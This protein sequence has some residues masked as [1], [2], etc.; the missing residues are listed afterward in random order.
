MYLRN[1]V[2]DPGENG[3]RGR[4]EAFGGPFVFQWHL[5]DRCERSCRHCYREGPPRRD[6]GEAG[7]LSVL[8][9][10]RAFLAKRGLRGRLHL[11]G[12]E[13]ALCPGLDR[14]LAA[15]ARAGLPFRF[16]TGGVGL[17][18]SRAADLARSGCVGVQVSVEGT[19]A[20]HDALRGE[21]GFRQAME[22]VCCARAAGLPVTL[23]MTL[24]R[25]NLADLEAVG[26]LAEAAA[27]RVY[28]SRLIPAGHGASL[29]V[30][31]NR[32]AWAGALRRI[33]ALADTLR[34]PV[35]LRDPT[36]RPLLA[37]PW[38]A[39]HSPAIS[40][41]SAGYRT[42][43]VESDGEVLPCRRLALPVGHALEGGLEQAWEAHPLLIALRDR[44]R[45]K[46]RCGRCAY[47]WVCGGCR[48]VPRAVSGDPFG[49]DPQCPWAGSALF[50]F[51]VMLLHLARQ[52]R[53]R[54]RLATRRFP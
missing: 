26:R 17:T 49:E 54:W 8:E 11:A 27:D 3:A 33:L 44:D 13:P 23:A 18:P 42:L 34:V 36:F 14:L 30:L 46:G 21:G 38:H 51:R 29:G 45:L 9:A 40:G 47:R 12:G 10:I 19:E 50:R 31:P 5:T 37:A 43:T 39:G 6:L 52:G 35:A 32:A 16:L 2:D 48:A 15:I 25:E 4:R 22:G 28:F 41:C 24:H 1:P 7:Q 53:F 20:T